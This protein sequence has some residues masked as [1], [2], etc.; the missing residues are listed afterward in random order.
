M[1]LIYERCTTFTL[2][3][4]RHALFSHCYTIQVCSQVHTSLIICKKLTG[5]LFAL[6]R[7]YVH[8]NIL[9]CDG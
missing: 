8:S 7:E 1:S 3:D 2:A 4:I 5:N 6:L 9:F